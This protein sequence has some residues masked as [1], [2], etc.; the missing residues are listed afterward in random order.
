M[1]TLVRPVLARPNPCRCQPAL[2]QPVTQQ[3]QKVAR[4][5]RRLGV[6]DASPLPMDGDMAIEG[7]ALAPGKA[8]GLANGPRM[9]FRQREAGAPCCVSGSTLPGQAGPFARIT[10]TRKDIYISNRRASFADRQKPAAAV[11]VS[12]RSA[13]RFGHQFPSFNPV[14]SG[15]HA[16]AAQTRTDGPRTRRAAH[17]HRTPPDAPPAPGEALTAAPA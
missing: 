4:R 8:S 6:S 14:R 2:S 1:A 12:A 11:S 10:H 17:P 16:K 15:R 9:P 3:A 5:S 7:Q 13:R